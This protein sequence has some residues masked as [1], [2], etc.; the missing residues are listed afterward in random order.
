MRFSSILAAI[1]LAFSTFPGHAGFQRWGADVEAD[2]FSN[3]VRVTVD[4]TSSARSGVLIICDTSEE[5]LMVRAIPGFSY[6]SSLML[7]D[8]KIEF[9][10]DGYRLFSQTG[11]TGA[12]G[13]NLAVAQVTL[14]PVNARVFVAAFAA[15]R[16]QIA[17]KDGISDRPHLMTARGST[18]AGRTLASC[19]NKQATP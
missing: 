2:P 13:D 7:I 10:F 1:L 8:P 16:K 12:V 9:A 4:Y 15:A 18:R 19:L 11:E 17:I 5:G 6:D 14:T 3:G